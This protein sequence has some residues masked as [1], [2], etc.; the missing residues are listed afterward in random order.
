MILVLECAPEPAS[1]F[2]SLLR[3]CK[4]T[5][6]ATSFEVVVLMAFPS[7]LNTAYRVGVFPNILSLRKN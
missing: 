6:F 7:E 4:N 5:Y 2:L 1:R 3:A